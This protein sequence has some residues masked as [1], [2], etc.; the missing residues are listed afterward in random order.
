MIPTR[1]GR[2]QFESAVCNT[3]L[4][5]YGLPILLGAGDGSRTRNILL[6]RQML[7]QLSYPRI[8]T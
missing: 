2:L 6:G 3:P 5:P 1:M 4:S 8:T 7:Y